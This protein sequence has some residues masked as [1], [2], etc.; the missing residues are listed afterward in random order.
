LRY[1]SGVVADAGLRL[2]LAEFTDLNSKI[3]RHA[4][5]SAFNVNNY[6]TATGL[7]L[8]LNHQFSKYLFATLGGKYQKNKYSE[9]IVYD[10]NYMRDLMFKYMLG[11]HRE[12]EITQWLAEVGYHFSQ[13]LSLRLNYVYEIG[14]AT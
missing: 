6:F 2:R 13:R 7:D 3:F 5:Q 8:N 4:E 11:Q 1:Y 12:D 9:G 14:I 10:P